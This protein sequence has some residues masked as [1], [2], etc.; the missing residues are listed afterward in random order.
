MKKITSTKAL[1]EAMRQ[2]RMQN[3]IDVIDEEQQELAMQ[4]ELDYDDLMMYDRYNILA[5]DQA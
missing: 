5:Q 3:V 4:E 2:Y 1:V